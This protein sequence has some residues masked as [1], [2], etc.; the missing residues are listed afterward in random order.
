MPNQL[1]PGLGG[2]HR[3]DHAHPQTPEDFILP[4]VTE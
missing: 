4:I 1:A 3:P 2:G